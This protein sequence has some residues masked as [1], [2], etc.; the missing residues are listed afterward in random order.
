MS[1]RDVNAR[2]LLCDAM[3]LPVNRD[4]STTMQ[5][6]T[7]GA[8]VRARLEHWGA[9]FALHRD[10]NNIGKNPKSLIALLME[11]GGELPSRVTGSQRLEVD[12]RAHAIEDMVTCIASDNMPM[13]CCLRGYYC[14]LGR[15]KVERFETANLLIA[16]CSGRPVS[17]RQYMLLVELGFQRIR[18]R[19]EGLAQV[20]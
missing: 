3:R 19:L 18:G 6:D 1:V 13:A 15:R 8:Y 5:V 11:Y 7:F 20:A 9:E 16:R 2:N 4:G 12:S 17:I 10:D 14:G